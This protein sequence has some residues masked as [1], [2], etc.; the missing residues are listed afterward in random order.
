MKGRYKIMQNKKQKLFV[1]ALALALSAGALGNSEAHAMTKVTRQVGVEPTEEDRNRSGEITNRD[2]SQGSSDSEPTKDGDLEDPVV[3]E[4]VVEEETPS[5]DTPSVEEPKIEEDVVEEDTPSEDSQSERDRLDR[6]FERHKTRGTRRGDQITNHDYYSQGDTD[7]APE[8]ETSFPN[9]NDDDE[10]KEEEGP[11][12]DGDIVDEGVSSEETP[13]PEDGE[14]DPSLEEPVAEE[15]SVESELPEKEKDKPFPS[16]DLSEPV[17]KDVEANEE[18]K[19][20][21]PSPE[22]QTQDIKK[23]PEKAPVSHVK[24]QTGGGVG[25]GIA[26]LLSAVVGGFTALK[27]HK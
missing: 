1:G 16:S 2:Y 26:G 12:E 9:P 7:D 6:M 25:V 23:V 19:V 17:D 24:A 8:G 4:D 21:E 15:N 20:V 11:S 3:E 18:E 22:R 5:E 14:E 27:K 10:S 13:A